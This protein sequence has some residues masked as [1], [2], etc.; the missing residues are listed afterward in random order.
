MTSKPFKTNIWNHGLKC[1]SLDAMEPSP[2][3]DYHGFSWII[4]H[5]FT[6]GLS[7]FS[8]KSSKKF[9]DLL[10]KHSTRRIAVVQVCHSSKA[11]LSQMVLQRSINTLIYSSRINESL[12]CFQSNGRNIS[13][14]SNPRN[15]QPLQLQAV[16]STCV[17][18]VKLQLA[19]I[20]WAREVLEMSSKA[21]VFVA[22]KMRNRT[23]CCKKAAPMVTCV[24]KLLYPQG[25]KG[26]VSHFEKWS[27]CLNHVEE[28]SSP[29]NSLES[30]GT[31]QIICYIGQWTTKPTCCVMSAH[32]LIH[33]C[34]NQWVFLRNY[35]CN[36]IQHLK[37]SYS[38]LKQAFFFGVPSQPTG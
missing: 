10:P 28:K 2:T 34:Q 14:S 30:V 37:G 22:A 27:P 31:Q 15:L 25:L 9:E 21:A 7:T 35:V 12:H 5:W 11:F 29:N 3:Q 18:H 16:L 4:L 26:R 8:S 33:T 32:T 24:R 19:A 38:D 36:L 6:F 13:K 20:A 23:I 1:E 17:P